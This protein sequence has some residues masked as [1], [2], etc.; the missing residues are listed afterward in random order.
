M[1]SDCANGA[2]SAAPPAPTPDE[3]RQE[4]EAETDRHLAGRRVVSPDPIYLSIVSP[5]VPN[6]TLIDMPGL[7]KVPIDGQP[8]SIV[9]DLDDMA[10]KYIRGPNAIVL[11]VSPANADLATSDALRL[12]R[13]VD[14]AGERTIGEQ[15]TPPTRS[16]WGFYNVPSCPFNPLEPVSPRSRAAAR[17]LACSAAEDAEAGGCTGVWRQRP[18]ASLPPLPLSPIASKHTAVTLAAS[19]PPNPC[20]LRVLYGRA[21]HVAPL[22]RL[23]SPHPSR[24]PTGV[25]T[26]VDIMDRGTDCRDVLLGKSVRLRHGWVAVVNR[27]QV[28][29]TL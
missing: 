17:P 28:C 25:L 14:P 8:A 3:I 24:L 4:I 23:P 6:L 11:A 12:A 18:T 27:A 20:T 19:L 7:T 15:A 26:K 5:T 21:P 1:H 22:C 10:R 9:Q 13:E 29:V 2:H 16:H